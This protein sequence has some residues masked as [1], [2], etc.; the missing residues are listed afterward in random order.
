MKRREFITLLSGAAAAWPLSARAQQAVMPV[1]GLLGPTSPDIN[2]NFVR[3]FRQGLKDTGYVEGDNV[4]IAY[5]WAEGQYDRLPVLA[6]ELVRRQVAVIAAIGG[7]PAAFAAKAATATI[8]I[9]FMA[10]EDPVSLNVGH[11]GRAESH[12]AS[13]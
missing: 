11:D 12:S 10:A 2:A 3:A 1:V 5:R 6:A 7:H 4:A 13:H 9:V 8:P